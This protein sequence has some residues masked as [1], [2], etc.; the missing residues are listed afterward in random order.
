MS[1]FPP[2]F[3]EGE[4]SMIKTL[5]IEDEIWVRKGIIKIIDWEGLGMVLSGE[6]ENG[7]DAV[8]VFKETNPDLVIM[9][10]KMPKYSGV[11]FLKSLAEMDSRCMVVVISGYSDY[12]YMKQAI[13]SGV[14]EYILKPVDEA[15]L[16]EVLH[17]VKKELE[18]RRELETALNAG[19]SLLEENFINL[20]V[21]E[22]EESR[23]ELLIN[24]AAAGM[25]FS[26]KYYSV[27]LLE[28]KGS[29]ELGHRKP[30]NSSN[31]LKNLVSEIKKYETDSFEI[32]AARSTTATDQLIIICKSNETE[33]VKLSSSQEEFC[34]HILEI[35]QQAHG[36]RLKAGIGGWEERCENIHKSFVQAAGALKYECMSG[37]DVI[38][39][40]KVSGMDRT[41]DYERMFDD[42]QVP[43]L[44]QD[45][46]EMRVFD[47]IE[48]LFDTFKESDY[49]YLPNVRKV[50]IGLML[51]VEK[52][53][54]GMDI[55]L[56]S[57]LKD[58]YIDSIEQFVAIDGLK[59]WTVKVMQD[60]VLQ[61]AEK[62]DKNGRNIIEV[63]KEYINTCYNEDINLMY[64]ARKY[65]L[66]HIYL[67]RLFKSH[68]GENFIDYLTRVRMDKARELL[69]KGN[70]KVKDVA[71]YVGYNN[72][73]YFAKSF[74]K[75]FGYS[76]SGVQHSD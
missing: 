36:V 21:S 42:R 4:A 65:Y 31:I 25:D 53:C 64:L 76:P 75:H 48:G 27:I 13:S 41:I 62:S 58:G 59:H 47:F 74:K 34:R 55:N 15:Y 37:P 72:P 24:A 69:E 7:M 2:I 68:T 73:Y 45:K 66:N 33:T 28:L 8:Q 12:E 26:N 23:G 29:F 16:N 11:D 3:R 20:M 38:F 51:A 35:W 5:I 39:F 1:G 32:N 54:A 71:E 70:L 30:G 40:E 57:I 6:A 60:I 52:H 17:N 14:F 67:S 19:K 61:I 9:D 44:L 18:S 56:K 43:Y 63:I 22:K 50:L 49:C 46:E 10:M